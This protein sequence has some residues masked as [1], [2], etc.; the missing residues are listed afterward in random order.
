ME[1]FWDSAAARPQFIW[2]LLMFEVCFWLGFLLIQTSLTRL[3]IGTRLRARGSWGYWV[4]EWLPYML[5]AIWA[6]V[7]LTLTL[8]YVEH[9][10]WAVVGFRLDSLWW[11][12]FFAGAVIGMAL[13]LAN[14]I[15]FTE[16]GWATIVRTF[17]V[18]PSEV[19]LSFAI[20]VV[21]PL[22]KTLAI[23]FW[24]EIVFRIYPLFILMQIIP[25]SQTSAAAIALV[26]LSAPFALA[27]LANKGA[28][29]FGV[30]G[31][32]AGAIVIGSGYI[33]TGQA[34]LTIGLHFAWNFFT[35]HIFG[36]PVSGVTTQQT[37]LVALEVNGPTLWTGGKFGPE[38]GIVAFGVMLLAGMVIVG[39]THL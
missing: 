25:G 22:M 32:A 33:L 37:T 16:K 23:G 9:S 6:G 21:A 29:W 36:F 27:H 31:I 11:R 39:Y 26:L 24:E 14:F 19:N 5:L 8:Q 38:T 4:N 35:G 1:L 7:S 20:A 34:A 13:G 15:I 2:R 18:M 12:D 10:T 3:K 17:Q 28:T 30:L